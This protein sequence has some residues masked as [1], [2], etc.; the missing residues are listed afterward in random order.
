LKILHIGYSDTSG[1][2]SIAMMRLH[3]S[4][5]ESGINSHVLVAEKKSNIKNVHGSSSS[6]EA[7]VSELKKKIVRQKKYIFSTNNINTHS[8][9]LFR[10]N[11]L[12][13][14]KKINPDIVN[15]HWVNNELISIKQISK[16]KEPLLWTINDMW[17]LCGCEHYSSSDR[18]INGYNDNNRDP[19]EKG[20]D[21]NKWTWN[22]KNK[23]WKDKF[24]AIICISEWLK[25]RAEQS[26]LFKN[27]K[28]IKI[29]CPIDTNI[30]NPVEKQK[31]RE[32]IG[33]PKDKKILLFVS[34]NGTRDERK[35]FKF[36]D[37]ALKKLLLDNE[38]I[39]LLIIGK[40]DIFTDKNYE[41]KVVDKIFNGNPN[42]LKKYYS[43]SDILLAPSK[44]EAFGQVAL[45]AAS[46]GV[47]TI[48]FKNTGIEDIITHKRNG[49]LANYCDQEDFDIGLKWLLKYT[50]DHQ[51]ILKNN[52]VETSYKFRNEVIVKKYLEI[53]K[54]LR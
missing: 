34:N 51:E 24:N 40:A 46:C 6:L 32:D 45:E 37:N 26:M 39:L 8:L 16:I 38:K 10:S 31:A 12:F 11:I 22:K 14:I 54:T 7:W 15:L 43:S 25:E 35:G 29:N 3:V 9:N 23:Y 36:V 53:Y 49:Y 17:P 27:K 33:L 4:M 20:F 41:Y 44:L 21:I 5:L 52:C 50:T 48:A 28:I 47:P 19:G 13:K 1:G 42:E 2:A 18:F 30:W